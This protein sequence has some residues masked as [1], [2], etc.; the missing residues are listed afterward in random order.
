M[1]AV[2]V[3]WLVVALLAWL[4]LAGFPC[5]HVC[6][7]VAADCTAGLSPPPPWVSALRAGLAPCPPSARRH[8]RTV[9]LVLVCAVGTKSPLRG[10]AGFAG[11]AERALPAAR[12]RSGRSWRERPVRDIAD[13]PNGPFGTLSVLNGPFGA[14]PDVPKAPF[15]AALRARRP[16]SGLDQ[17]PPVARRGQAT[18]SSV[19]PGSTPATGRSR[20]RNHLRG[21]PRPAYTESVVRCGSAGAPRSARATP[22]ELRIPT[23]KLT[24][25]PTCRTSRPD[26]AARQAAGSRSSAR[27][28]ACPRRWASRRPPSS[29]AGRRR[30][31]LR[32]RCPRCRD[33]G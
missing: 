29:A 27:V 3:G 8:H 15:A 25:R 22:E 26:T 11:L 28:G 6:S 30:R 1:I 10:E 23:T 19:D 5:L 4:W 33:A 24:G 2:F 7:V 31:W 18:R 16:R 14:S 17:A 9:S 20:H 32:A 12:A 21:V 13:V